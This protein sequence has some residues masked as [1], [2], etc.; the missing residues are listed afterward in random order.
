MGGDLVVGI[1]SMHENME[2]R[3]R[4]I[5]RERVSLLGFSIMSLVFLY[6]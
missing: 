6:A 3:G 2:D 4:G 5:E 1:F